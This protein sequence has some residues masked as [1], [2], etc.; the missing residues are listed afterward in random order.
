M[1]DKVQFC[2]RALYLEETMNVT[3]ENI[4]V[5]YGKIRNC[6]NVEFDESLREET[7]TLVQ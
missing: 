3:I 6:L 4:A 2:A 5:F 1:H 7:F